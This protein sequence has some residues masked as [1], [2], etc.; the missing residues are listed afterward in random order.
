MAKT[1]M[2]ARVM[3]QLCY[4]DMVINCDAAL[5]SNII[6][7]CSA[8]SLIHSLIYTPKRNM[9]QICINWQRKHDAKII[10]KWNSVLSLKAVASTYATYFTSVLFSQNLNLLVSATI[11][12]S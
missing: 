4:P 8:F 12:G 6:D 7:F 2:T 9:I 5:R 3:R 1:Y 11:M 10:H